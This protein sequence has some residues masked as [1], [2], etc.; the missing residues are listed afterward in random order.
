MS[1]PYLLLAIAA[2]LAWSQWRTTGKLAPKAGFGP[3]VFMLT[4]WPVLVAWAVGTSGV[5][6]LLLLAALGRGQVSPSDL[7]RVAW[8]SLLGGLTFATIIVGVPFLLVRAAATPP[9]LA[10]EP[11]E[12][13]IQERRGRQFLR[14][15][16]RWGQLLL[17]NRRIGFRPSR[18]N[19]QRSPWSMR[20]D[21]IRSV[22]VEGECL[23]VVEGEAPRPPEWVL[24]ID[25]RKM[26]AQLDELR[27]RPEAARGPS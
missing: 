10:L 6:L 1:H 13:L 25:G 26:A 11:G 5:L 17:T 14:G 2:F 24:A 16:S 3:I 7:L 27:G 12:V 20:L 19:V 21:D 23:L 22:R 18:F 8:Q 9:E 15:E 4:R